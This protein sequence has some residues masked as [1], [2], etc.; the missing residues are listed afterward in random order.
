LCNAHELPGRHPEADH[1]AS[2]DPAKTW[3]A[4]G[5]IAGDAIH[6]RKRT[7][8]RG[9]RYDMD[10]EEVTEEPLRDLCDI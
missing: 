9:T 10:V 1:A 2:V 7:V 3:Q 4:E 5:S 8:D 6:F